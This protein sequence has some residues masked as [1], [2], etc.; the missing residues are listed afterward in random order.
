MKFKYSLKEEILKGSEIELFDYEKNR[1][2]LNNGII[3]LKEN[4]L[5]R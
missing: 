4:F 1:Y 3:K 5:E 2:L